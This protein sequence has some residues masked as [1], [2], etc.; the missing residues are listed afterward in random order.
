MI[1]CTPSRFRQRL[2][3]CGRQARIWRTRWWIIT[4][5]T[6]TP[7]TLDQ[8]IPKRL[9]TALKLSSGAG[10]PCCTRS[11]NSVL[12]GKGDVEYIS[13]AVADAA[14]HAITVAKS[15]HGD[16]SLANDC[17]WTI[18]TILITPYSVKLETSQ[19]GSVTSKEP[20]HHLAATDYGHQ[21]K[22]LDTLTLRFEVSLVADVPEHH[23]R[24]HEGV[25]VCHA[26]LIRCHRILE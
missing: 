26:L 2:Q 14:G 1:S 15:G 16:R 20:T 10:I 3:S 8:F 12:S 25:Q 13:L 4:P 6:P 22:R 7:D 11:G 18:I 19:S 24:M 21:T 23:I 9:N 17:L 5:T